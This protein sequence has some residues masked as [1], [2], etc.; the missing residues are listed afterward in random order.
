MR[1]RDYM[2]QKKIDLFPAAAT[3]A[4]SSTRARVLKARFER[5]GEKRFNV[6]NSRASQS[7]LLGAAELPFRAIL[8]L[9][10][11]NQSGIG[12]FRSAD[13][14]DAVGARGMRR[15]PEMAGFCLPRCGTELL[16]WFW[17][18]RRR[19]RSGCVDVGIRRGASPPRRKL[20]KL[21]TVD[22]VHIWSSGCNCLCQASR[23]RSSRAA[24]SP[25]CAGQMSPAKAA[26]E[27]PT[28]RWD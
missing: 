17:R 24:S 26:N 22:L 27:P 9:D 10:W 20:A 8:K 5:D 14:E 21:R 6:K 16:R 11:L 18:N 12:A 25:D 7:G 28:T 15:R 19:I 2:V 3:K 23:E 4:K 13:H 1:A